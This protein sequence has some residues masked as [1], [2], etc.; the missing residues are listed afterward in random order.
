MA[1]GH[2]IFYPNQTFEFKTCGT[3]NL[4]ALSG[5]RDQSPGYDP[6]K[7]P[8]SKEVMM[9]KNNKI[10]SLLKPNGDAADYEHLSKFLKGQIYQ[11][12]AKMGGSVRG[13]S[14]NEHA[15]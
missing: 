11:Q 4:N 12:K 5:A 7:K 15:R 9:Y 14:L 2:L 8:I 1:V 6:T 10:S 3:L 13:G